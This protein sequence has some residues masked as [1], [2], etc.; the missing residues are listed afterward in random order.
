[1]Q[2]VA[3][4]RGI[5]VGGNNKVSMADLKACFE[6][7]GYKDVAT[8][9]NSG[10]LLFSST[11]RDEVSLV[12]T[13]EKAIEKQ[14]G[15][16]VVVMIMRADDLIA[17][18]DD[19]PTW[20]G[21]GDAK[22]VRNEALFVIPPTLA[23]DVL[24]QIEKKSSTVDQLAARGQVIFWTLPKQSYNKSVVPKIIGTPIYR[25]ITMRGVLTT[26]RLYELAKARRS[27]QAN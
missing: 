26:Q 3:L 17:A 5:N 19:A 14:F 22:E 7:L 13:C 24:A 27:H 6:A 1:M 2:Y 16:P 15:F 21:K 11:D 12:E 8:Y 9:I 18:V 20:W 23:A 4:L 25:R 10:N